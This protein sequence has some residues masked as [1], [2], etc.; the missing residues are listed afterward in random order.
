MNLVDKINELA[1][2]SLNNPFCDIFV[3]NGWLQIYRFIKSHPTKGESFGI[4][5][6]GSNIPNNDRNEIVELFIDN[7]LELTAPERE[8]RM[9]QKQ[10]TTCNICP[11]SVH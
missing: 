4:T 11:P 9:A 3:R 5:T 7:M 1:L 2:S 10:F 6:I 8:L